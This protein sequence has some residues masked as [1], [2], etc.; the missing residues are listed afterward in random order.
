MACTSHARM[1]LAFPSRTHRVCMACTSTSHVHSIYMACPCHV[2]RTHAHS[3][4]MVAFTCRMRIACTS[5]VDCKHD[6]MYVAMDLATNLYSPDQMW[7]DIIKWCTMVLYII[8]IKVLRWRHA[9]LCEGTTLSRRSQIR[10]QHYCNRY[11]TI[12]LSHTVDTHH[13]TLRVL[14]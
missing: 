5:R 1:D 2:H 13:D 3:I 8:V 9:V 11:S 10:S 7:H 6:L 12:I 4:Y 14:S